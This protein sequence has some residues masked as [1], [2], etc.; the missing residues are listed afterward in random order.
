MRFVTLFD[1]H[2]L[3]K[4]KYDTYIVYLCS[5][6]VVVVLTV[7]LNQLGMDL[8]VAGTVATLSAA[9]AISCAPKARTVSSVRALISK[10]QTF[11]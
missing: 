1:S 3:S 5:R 11:Q 2:F 6:N 7:T 8:L 10:S 9:D 4:Y